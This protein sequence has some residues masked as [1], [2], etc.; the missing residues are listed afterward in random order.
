MHS[1]AQQE[2]DEEL[3]GI[4]EHFKVGAS[5]E[6]QRG[7]DHE[8][9]GHSNHMTRDAGSGHE[10]GSNGILNTNMKLNSLG[11]MQVCSKVN[12]CLLPTWQGLSRLFS[13]L[14][15]FFS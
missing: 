8:E 12:H 11:K 15:T 7:R 4:P 6:L 3:V 1:Q 9:E 5:D 14:T 10:T 13:K 2:D